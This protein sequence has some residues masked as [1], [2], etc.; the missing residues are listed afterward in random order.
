WALNKS[1]LHDV[2]AYRVVNRNGLLTGNKHFGGSETMRELLENE[3]V[4]II[5]NQIQDFE[6]HFWNPVTELE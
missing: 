3:G 4:I 1:G 6:K 2:P 5:E